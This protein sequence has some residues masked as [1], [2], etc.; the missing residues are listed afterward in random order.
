MVQIREVT[1]RRQLKEFIRFPFKLY[2]N[3]PN[4]V[5]PLISDEMDTLS[6]NKNPAFD[7]CEAK[8][9][10]AYRDNKVVG[11]IAGIINHRYIE[12]WEKHQAR[13]G[14]ID[15][16]E[17]IEVARALT[18]AVEEWAAAK[19]MDAVHGP[20][21][22]CDLDKEGM[23]IEGFNELSMMITIYNA[24][25]YPEFMEKLGYSKDVDW[26]EFEIQVPQQL[27]ERV[28]K[29][30]DIVLKRMKLKILPAKKSSDFLP[31]AKEVFYLVNEAYKDL[32]GVVELTEKQIDA[33]VKQYFGFVNPDYVRIILNQDDQLVAFGIA[34]PSLALAMKKANGRAFPFGI[35][36]LMKALKK[37][38]RLDLYLVAVKPELQG[39]GVNALILA[40]INQTAIK[41]GVK[42][43][44]TGPELEENKDVQGLWKFYETRQHKKRRCYIKKLSK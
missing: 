19:G 22:F 7:F 18:N 31:Y 5:P 16:I 12:K 30:N 38:D 25:Y 17:D 9:W 33:Y 14:W 44:E 43:A 24:P 29:I 3:N 37:N 27:P 4:W 8:Y 26:L 21:G 39:K 15:F 41:N 40:D 10:L 36:H 23:L 1:T 2:V 28:V 35:L 42:F 20:L 11:R 13:F 32:Y 34:L 6:T